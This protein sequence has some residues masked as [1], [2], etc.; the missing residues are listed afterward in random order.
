MIRCQHCGAETTNGLALC[1]LCCEYARK[2]LEIIPTYFRNLARWRP[3]RAGSRPVPG[4]R[5][6]Y[7]GY[8]GSGGTGDRISDALDE[9][10][11]ALTTWARTLIDARPGRL[12]RLLDR[13]S[14]ARREE[15]I[16]EAQA[17][18]WLCKGFDR[19][20]VSIATTDWCGEFV[21][22]LGGQE[23]RLRKLTEVAVP[24][25]YAG[26]CRQVVGFDETGAAVRCGISTY[27]VPGFTW[28]T[29][30][31]CGATTHAG[32]HLEV[33]LE[34]ARDWTARPKALAEATVALVATE[35]SVPRLYA[36]IR[37]WASRGDL[38]ATR[39]STRGYG[40]D[41]EVKRMVV[42]D[43][44]IGH[45]KYRL[46]DVLDRVHSEGATRLSGSAEGKA[47]A[48]A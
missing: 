29:C 13:L 7:D 28:V 4:S 46:G 2:C 10:A 47:H 44:E 26:G 40:W 16:D 8:E 33:I 15:R 39:R 41:E 30:R 36:R 27:V 35:Q 31:G 21:R 11:N 32:D 24:G 25:W 37:Q 19:H 6:L 48:L 1:A 5:V 3:G 34:E 18:A 20:L 38:T 43:E 9:A 14:D 12:T 17:V 45:A 22:D 23:T 42:I